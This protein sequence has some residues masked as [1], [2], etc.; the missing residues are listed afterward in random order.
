MR[1]M[2]FALPVC[3]SFAF[4]LSADEI[5]ALKPDTATAQE[6]R[7]LG[8]SGAALPGSRTVTERVA[9]QKVEYED[10]V[11]NGVVT[12]RPVIKTTY[13][14]RPVIVY[15]T[16]AVPTPTSDAELEAL[17]SELKALRERKVDTLDAATLA[18]EVQRERESARADDAWKKLQKIRKELAELEGQYPGTP[19]AGFARTAQ[20]V[21]PIEPSGVLM[22]TS[23]TSPG[24]NHS[25]PG[26][27]PVP[28]PANSSSPPTPRPTY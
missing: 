3:A 21:I 14:D 9:V 22:P 26:S 12:K 6:D 15:A 16:S 8:D 5:P 4:P 2:L 20:Q 10:V 11:N 19:A 7:H 24:P 25:L 17:R 27:A 28:I 13:E 18:R 1:R 23:H